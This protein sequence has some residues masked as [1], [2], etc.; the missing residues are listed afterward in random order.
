MNLASS[1][2][3]SDEF[4][5]QPGRVRRQALKQ[6]TS[7]EVPDEFVI[8]N[9]QFQDESINISEVKFL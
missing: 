4:R 1:L 9:P 5:D 3:T 2:L 6:N 8:V 7:F